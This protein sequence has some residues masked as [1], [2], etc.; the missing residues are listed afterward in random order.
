MSTRQ[1]TYTVEPLIL[2]EGY[3]R[4]TEWFQPRAA[5][6]PPHSVVVTASQAALWGSDIF[7][8]IWEW[9]SDDLGRTWRGPRPHASLD[10]RELPGGATVAACDL[11]PAWHAASGKLLATGHT[12]CYA[13]G[14]QGKLLADNSF[15]RHPCWSVYDAAAELWAPWQT[16]ELPDRDRFWWA[17]AGC[18]QRWDLPSGEILLP[19]YTMD[20]ASVGGNFWHSCFRA[21]VVRCAFDGTTLSLLEQGDELTIGDPRGFCEPSLTHWGEHYYLTLRNDLR[22]Y[23]SRSRDGLHYEPPRPWTFDDGQELGSY[24]TQQHWVRHEAGLFLAY[25]RRGAG[26]DEVIRHRAPLFCAE[27]DPDRLVVLR[28][29]EQVLVPNRGAQLGNFGV[30]AISPDETWVITSEAMH[31]DAQDPSNLELTE[32]RGARQRVWIARLR[33]QLA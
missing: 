20:R 19:I 22:G 9:R 33:W 12:A 4:Q 18:T 23:V 31:G 30:A 11:T 16:L 32:S 28:D 14:E 26:N 8:A 6:L 15:P 21:T 2:S 29:T 13:T 1:V 24:N 17:G 25:T 5:L 27:V 7:H 3:D 10:R